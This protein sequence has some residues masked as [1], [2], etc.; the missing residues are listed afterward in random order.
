[1]KNKFLKDI[2]AFLF[3]AIAFF[4]FI[5]SS[6]SKSVHS[7]PDSEVHIECS[8]LEINKKQLEKDLPQLKGISSCK[9]SPEVG[10][11][12]IEYN[13]EDFSPTSVKKILN[14]WEI[15]SQNEEEWQFE[16]IASSE[17]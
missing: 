11:I 9:I 4:L 13:S 17:F 5:N 1:M 12:S 2:T 6:M 15:D 10:I 8:N 7:K 3:V 16:I 14:K